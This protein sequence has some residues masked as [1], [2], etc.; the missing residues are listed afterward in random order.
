MGLSSA[1]W[2]VEL[3]PW[4]PPT[5]Y[6]ELSPQQLEQPKLCP[7]RAQC[8][9]GGHH[10]PADEKLW[11][12]YVRADRCKGLRSGIWRRCETYKE[13]I[14]AIAVGPSMRCT[15]G[16]WEPKVA[17]S[18]PFLLGSGRLYLTDVWKK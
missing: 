6:Q 5:G 10:H 12:G 9:L 2:G 14:S 7:E 1:L 8:P 4:D 16:P 17:V 15:W 3:Q 13:A 18:K 11:S